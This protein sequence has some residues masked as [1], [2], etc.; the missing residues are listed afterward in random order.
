MN[1]ML[2]LGKE[3]PL[4]GFNP[5]PVIASTS[6]KKSASTSSEGSFLQPDASATSAASTLSSA[7]GAL[8]STLNEIFAGQQ[9]TPSAGTNNS[10]PITLSG[11][12]SAIAGTANVE[13]KK[14]MNAELNMPALEILSGYGVNTTAQQ[15]APDMQ[16]LLGSNNDFHDA[17]KQVMHVAELTQTSQSLTPMR[18]EMEI[19]TPPGAIVNVYVSKQ[20]DQWRAQLSTNDPQALA[21]VQDQMSSLRQSNDLGVS[22]RWLPPQLES[23]SIATST[24]SNGQDA[25]L[26]W[27]R[28]GQGQS[29]YQQPDERSQSHSQEQ[30]EDFAELT[31]VG[32]NP[33]LTSFAS[34]GRAA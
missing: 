29:N 28:G 30:T 31:A 2:A 5:A 14:A 33:F 15:K 17:L 24:S 19:Q 26:G 18:V 10:S 11:G 32:A 22:V 16:I 27:D 34:L 8:L 20:N 6:E 21:W 23:G 25:N 1:A 9:V 4:S 12:A 3:L 13:S 7:S